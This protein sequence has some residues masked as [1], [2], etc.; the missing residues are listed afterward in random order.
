M[1]KAI[2]SNISAISWQLVLV[3][4]EPQSPERT[5]DH[6]E[7]TSKLISLAAAIRVHVFVIYKAARY[8]DRCMF[9]CIFSSGHDVVCSFSIYG[10]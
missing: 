3:V 1:F 7:A 4:G 8:V 10:F 6:W 5:T 9:F 2:F